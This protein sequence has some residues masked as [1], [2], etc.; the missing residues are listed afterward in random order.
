[1]LPSAPSSTDNFLGSPEDVRVGRRR[2]EG[3]YFA[4]LGFLHD[5]MSKSRAGKDKAYEYNMDDYGAH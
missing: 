5:V 2:D 1:M 4:L 3:Y